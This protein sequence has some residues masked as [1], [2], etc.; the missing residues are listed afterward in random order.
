M[1]RNIQITNRAYIPDTIVSH[2]WL[3]TDRSENFDIKVQPP[4]DSP[5]HTRPESPDYLQ[6]RFELWELSIKV[7]PLNNYPIDSQLLTLD[8]SVQPDRSWDDL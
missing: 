1:F 8:S 7:Q 4:F 5:L 3:N 2:S 6:L